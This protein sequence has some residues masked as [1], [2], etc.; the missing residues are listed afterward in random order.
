LNNTFERLAASET[1]RSL[2]DIALELVQMFGATPSLVPDDIPSDVRVRFAATRPITVEM[3]DD[4]L[5]LTLR[6]VRLEND[7]GLELTNFVVRA[8]YRTQIDGLHAVL[9]RD[10]VL[11]ISGPR[12]G[13]RERLPIRAVFNK[14]LNSDHVIPLVSQSLAEHPAADGLRVSQLELIDGWLGMSISPRY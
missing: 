10:G 14:V 2:R 1:P 8:S 7:N 6:I 5:W 9:V 3:E 12:M 11:H 13:M 4:L